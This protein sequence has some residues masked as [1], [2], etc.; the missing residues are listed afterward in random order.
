LNIYSHSFVA[1]CPVNGA[2]IQYQLAIH[3]DRKIM[4]ED[5]VEECTIGSG[6]HEDI[7]D[8]LIRRL[9]GLQVLQAHHHGVDIVTIRSAP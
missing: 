3:T 9:G 1:T 8:E 7:A 2:S 6:F 4:V 5:I